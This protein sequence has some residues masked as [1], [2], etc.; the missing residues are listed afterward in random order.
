MNERHGD[1]RPMEMKMG[2]EGGGEYGRERRKAF[3]G[4]SGEASGASLIFDPPEIWFP[5]P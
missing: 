2:R 4:E 5:P 1:K 3:E